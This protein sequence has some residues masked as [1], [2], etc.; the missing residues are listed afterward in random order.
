MEHERPFS[1]TIGGH[2][3]PA[4]TATCNRHH[5]TP[6]IKANDAA[7]LT[8]RSRSAAPPPRRPAAPPKH[9]HNSSSSSNT[10]LQHQQQQQQEQARQLQRQ[11]QRQ[12]QQQQ[13]I[14]P[15]ADKLATSIARALS[16]LHTTPTRDLSPPHDALH[17]YS[18][19]ASTAA[20]GTAAAAAARSL[21]PP[22]RLPHSHRMLPHDDHPYLQTG[23]THASA[24]PLFEHNDA[25][26]AAAWQAAGHGGVQG[27]IV[28][29][30]HEPPSAQELLSSRQKALERLKRMRAMQ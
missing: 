21:S 25:A 8:S 9:K 28:Q 4:T 18:H 7:G 26:H 30:Y 24:N 6:A 13:Q 23:P 1:T 29:G 27:G 20:A 3:A 14:P 16:P 19:T 11:R 15:A 5:P 22:S 12:R 17:P 2:T 10:S